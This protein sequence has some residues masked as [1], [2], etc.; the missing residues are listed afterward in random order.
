[1]N[2]ESSLTH[3]GVMGMRWGTRRGKLYRRNTM[4]T[5]GRQKKLDEHD[6]KRLKRNRIVDLRS[7]HQKNLDKKKI[8]ILEARLDKVKN[9]KMSS[10][11]K[12]RE[13]HAGLK[14][15]ARATAIILGVTV[16]RAAHS[17]VKMN[18]SQYMA[19]RKLNMYG[20][21]DPETVINAHFK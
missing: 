12:N 14:R 7:P 5:S 11:P 3:T 20:G 6:L 16:G 1:M 19:D 8:A 9:K 13:K 21:F 2:Q 10:Y 18:L 17:I 15:A 4:L